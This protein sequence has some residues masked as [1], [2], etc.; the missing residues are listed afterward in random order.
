ML[1]SIPA[2]AQGDDTAEQD[3]QRIIEEAYIEGVFV[4]RDTVAVRAG[5]HPSFVMSV[6]DGDEIIVAS[7]DM[8][9]ERLQLD[10]EPSSDAIRTVFD[11]V[12]V[13]DNT[14][15]VKLQFWI[16]GNHTYTDYIGLYRF[17]DR[18]KIVTKVFATHD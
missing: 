15:A 12:D 16:N 17:S 11:R 5:F 3:V 2:L 7:L 4:Q 9:L 1:W 13:T 18:W 8:W 14:A 10:G 6:L